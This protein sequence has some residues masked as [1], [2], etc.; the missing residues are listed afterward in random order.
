M[1]ISDPGLGHSTF[2]YNG[3]GELVRQTDANG[4]DTRFERDAIGRVTQRRQGNVVADFEFDHDLPSI[5]K[6]SSSRSSTGYDE[7]Y[8]YDEFGRLSNKTITTASRTYAIAWFY[9]DA[10]RVGR[11]DY[12]NAEAIRYLYSA[13]GILSEIRSVREDRSLWKVDAYDADGHITR[14]ALG[15]SLVATREFDPN[16]SGMRRMSL[17]DSRATTLLDLTNEYDLEEN[18]VSRKDQLSGLNEAF[19]YDA[20]DRLTS[21]TPVTG[22]DER[23]LMSGVSYGADG[24]ILRKSFIGGYFYGHLGA[25]PHA[26]SYIGQ[27]SGPQTIRYDSNGSCTS[28]LGRVFEYSTASMPNRVTTAGSGEWVDDHL[29]SVAFR[30]DNNDRRIQKTSRYRNAFGF[31]TETVTT[32]YVNGLYERTAWSCGEL[33]R[34]FIR[35]G[36]DLIAVAVHLDERCR[37]RSVL[38]DDLR[39][40]PAPSQNRHRVIDD[41]LFVHSDQIG[42][43]IGVSAMSGSVLSTPRYDPFGVRAAAS[44]SAVRIRGVNRGI[45]GREHDDDLGLI[46]FNAR[47]FDPHLARFLSADTDDHYPRRPQ[48]YNRYSL[49]LNNPLRFTDST[50]QSVDSEGV[51]HIV[52]TPDPEAEDVAERNALESGGAGVSAAPREMPPLTISIGEARGLLIEDAAREVA[53]RNGGEL[54]PTSF[55]RDRP[56]SAHCCGARDVVIRGVPSAEAAKQLAQALGPG[57]M[58]VNEDVRMAAGEGPQAQRNTSYWVDDRGRLQI[59]NTHPWE[60]VT[61]RSAFGG[62]P[63]HVHIQPRNW[64][65]P[66]SQIV[67]PTPQ[68]PLP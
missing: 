19:S 35:A 63:S 9:D 28:G 36:D 2:S 44:L 25:G 46:N 30:Y 51:E 62:N 34:S 18:V 54:F 24:N 45:A 32:D 26:V 50:G 21:W 27:P 1:R 64:H 33:Q 67:R 31:T 29:K 53:R 58:V 43:V 4:T 5:G 12:P 23:A 17:T 49:A 37:D 52:V 66:A 48:E 65:P 13:E 59:N 20:L 47:L 55:F 56:D 68:P 41:V 15:N 60:R 7:H 42:S 39:H 61:A 14:S 38:D 57:W 10:G 22:D 8:K 3:F 11:I 40:L 6:M 16:Q